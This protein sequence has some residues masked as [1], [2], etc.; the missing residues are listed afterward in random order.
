M[1][2]LILI[3]LLFSFSLFSGCA[4]MKPNQTIMEKRLSILAMQNDTLT[5]LYDEKPT[6]RSQI[7][8]SPGFAVFNSA[9]VN[10]LIASFSGGN[11]ILT[12]NQTGETIF[13][14][15]GEIG[16]G[17]GA[18]VK[19][20][21]IVFI[22]HT[23]E[24]MQRFLHYGL[25]VGGH[26]DAAAKAGDKGFSLSQEMVADNVTVYQLTESGLA[27]QATLKGTKY[28]RSETLNQ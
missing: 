11:G 2:H 26:A 4:T 15:M 23:D 9:N 8:N 27:L 5:K 10:V 19:D 18:G 21:R 20:F 17:L 28:W 16:L 14:N 24:A 7:D 12:N 25:T 22:F 3:S 13:M 1:K 6:V